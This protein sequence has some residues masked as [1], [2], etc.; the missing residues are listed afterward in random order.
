MRDE[1]CADYM[2]TLVG[3][4]FRA[5]F[6]SSSRWAVRLAAILWLRDNISEGARQFSGARWQRSA[7][8]PAGYPQESH[9]R[10]GD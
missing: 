3:K 1:N 7:S 2:S 5:S 6:A 9:Q 10:Q 4:L 8:Q